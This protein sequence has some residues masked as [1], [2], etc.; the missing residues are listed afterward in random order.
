MNEEI[1]VAIKHR[2][3]VKEGLPHLD[4]IGERGKREVF[5]VRSSTHNRSSLDLI[6]ARRVP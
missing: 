1:V 5:L 6:M 2:D 3:Q 4:N